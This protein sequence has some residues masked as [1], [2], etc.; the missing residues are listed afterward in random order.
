MD[1]LKLSRYL[2]SV[3]QACFYGGCT[4]RRQR[5]LRLP[6]I[7][8]KTGFNRS[9][10]HALIAKGEFPRSIRIGARAVGWLERYR[11]VD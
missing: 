7:K 6:E 8:A 10:I 2:Q 11:P 5:I 3:G 1:N 4:A 9:T